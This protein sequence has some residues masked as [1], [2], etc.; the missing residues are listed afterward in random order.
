MTKPDQSTLEGVGRVQGGAEV[1]LEG[2]VGGGKRRGRGGVQLRSVAAAT[3]EYAHR[4]YR[5]YGWLLEAFPI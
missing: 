3:P 1:A 2:T 5:L 4:D